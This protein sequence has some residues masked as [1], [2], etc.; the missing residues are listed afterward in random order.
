LRADEPP[1]AWIGDQFQS[2]LDRYPAAF[3]LLSFGPGG[4]LF[5]NMH[6]E[7][8]Y[9]K[10]APG[11]LAMDVV[12][13]GRGRHAATDS[14]FLKGLSPRGLDRAQG[15]VDISFGQRPALR[16]PGCHE[17]YLTGPF[18]GHGQDRHLIILSPFHSARPFRHN[19]NTQSTRAILN[20]KIEAMM[21]DHFDECS[22][23][24]DRL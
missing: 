9:P 10:F 21:L 12:A 18:G 16:V 6:L 22:I 7:D 20:Q 14:G 1:E 23:L 5:P 24:R 17:K 4:E 3:A 13:D 2:E 19:R 11:R 8:P 15:V